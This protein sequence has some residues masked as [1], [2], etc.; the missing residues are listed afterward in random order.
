MKNEAEKINQQSA[1]GISRYL[2]ICVA[3]ILSVLLVLPT[4]TIFA[5]ESN[6]YGVLIK[7]NGQLDGDAFARTNAVVKSVNGNVLAIELRK[8]NYAALS[9][10]KGVCAVQLDAIYNRSYNAVNA[11]ALKAKYAG[12]N[13]IVGILDNTGMLN[14]NAITGLKK[15]ESKANVGFISYISNN[16]N[17]VVIMRNLKGGESNL[18][19]SLTY[20]KQYAATVGKPLVIEMLLNGDEMANP[21]FVQV[22]QRMADAGIQFIGPNV[23]QHIINNNAPI[24]LAFTMYSTKTGRITD[25]SAY[26]AINEIMGQELMLLGSDNKTC[27]IQFNTESGFEKIFL[28]NASNDAV[29][30]SAISADGSVHYYTIENKQTALIP[31]NL[32]NGLPVLEDGTEGVFPYLSKPA[33]FNGTGNNNRMIALNND[34]QNIDLP[35]TQMGLS[36][37]QKESGFLQMQLEN[38]AQNLVIEIKNKMGKVVY[39]NN[40][41]HDIESLQAKIDLSDGTAGLYFL[42]LTSPEFHRTFALLMD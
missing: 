18:I 19:Q 30:V 14:L 6:K 37:S 13:I 28:S 27:S 24:Q 3:A 39:L 20:M 9:A 23:E 36:L 33:L 29:M 21:L 16:K 11:A 8:E 40:P 41:E 32:F 10:I 7:V 35:S 4:N 25:R 26:W 15:V 12:A 31:R 2:S 17:S 1:N 42:E 5:D 22:C 38:I 34:V